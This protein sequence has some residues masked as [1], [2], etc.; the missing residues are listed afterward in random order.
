M[1]N[2]QEVLDTE[3]L[4]LKITRILIIFWGHFGETLVTTPLLECLRKRF[5]NSYI[6]FVVGGS[7]H[8]LFEHAGTMLDH[9]PHISKYIQSDESILRKIL[10]EDPYDVA[11]DLCGGK[12]SR[13][14]AHMSSAKIKIW[15]RFR[16]RPEEFFY[17]YSCGGKWCNSIRVPLR[18]NASRIEQFL[19][20]AHLLGINIC[21]TSLPK[22][23]L[24][25]EEKK[26]G[27]DYLNNVKN[28]KKDIVIALH[29]GGRNPTR[30][31]DPKNYALLT[32]KLIERMRVKVIVFHGPGERIFAE[33]VC[34]LANNELITVFENDIRK[35]I[36]I[37]SGCNIFISTDGGPLHIALALKIA[38]VGLF[39]D[40][41]YMNYWYNPYKQKGLLFPVIIGRSVATF[42]E[43]DGV[44]NKVNVL[45]QLHNAS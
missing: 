19:S 10:C 33:R 11:I 44:F 8:Q 3:K 27:L 43:V 30:L 12:V 41:K 28:K 9:N 14:I 7:G 13:L 39:K 38:S 24:S 1:A 35:Y 22:I 29:P 23:Y 17:S 4:A 42:D 6:T 34:N 40:K 32:D 36:A 21:A 2:C 5:P 16:E 15:G 31:W 26:F 18:K 25:K 37:I 45:L 20:I